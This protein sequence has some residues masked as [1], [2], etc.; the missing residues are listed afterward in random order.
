MA[1]FCG[2]TDH[3]EEVH[4]NNLFGAQLCHLMDAHLVTTG[5]R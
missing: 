3:P 2:N 4:V 5:G 1:R